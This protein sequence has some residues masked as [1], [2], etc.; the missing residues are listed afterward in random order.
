MKALVHFEVEA[1]AKH[2]ASLA[3]KYPSMMFEDSNHLTF[4]TLSN[5]RVSSSGFTNGHAISQKATLT[6]Y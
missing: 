6:C 5:G 3:H 1:K 2:K 4:F